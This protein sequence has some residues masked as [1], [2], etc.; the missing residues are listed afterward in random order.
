MGCSSPE[1]SGPDSVPSASGK[2][3]K[4]E[5]SQSSGHLY[6][7]AFAQMKSRIDAQ[8]DQPLIV[9][10]PK[11]A[12]GGYTHEQH[13][14]NA[15][16]IFE[17]G[18]LFEASGEARY[19]D[20]LI[21][22]LDEY[23]GMYSDLPLHPKQKE[24]TPGRLFWQSL[25]EAWWL[26]HAAQGYD[27]IRASLDDET[28]TRVEDGLFHPMVEFL[29][30]GQPQT[31]DK[32]HNHGTWATAAVGLTGY[33]L[34][35]EDYVEKA[36]LGLDLSGEGGFLRQLNVLFSPD[37]YYNE[38]PYY[39]RYALMP[40]VLFAQAIQENEP[41]RDI[42]GQR[43]EILKKAIY[44]TI[45]Q[46]YGG[47]FF[48]INDAIK[49]KDIATTELLHGVS[50]AY[51]LTGDVSLLSIAEAQNRVVP[52]QAG[53]AVSKAINAGKSKPFDYRSMRLADGATG[54]NGAL[55]ILRES[56]DPDGMAV[57]IKNT[58]QG[59]GHG[60]FDKMGLLVFDRGYEILRDYGASRFLNI[61]AK[62]GGHYL[63]ENNLYAKQTIAH[64][65]LVVD[66]TSHFN[67]KTE[68]GNKHAPILGPFVIGEDI[69]ATSA[70]MDTAYPGVTLQRS[71]ALVRHA[72]LEAPILI[73]VVKAK[74]EGLHDYDLPYHY[75][76]QIIE[77]NYEIDADTTSRKPL[78]SDN[79]YQYL[80]QVGEAELP[81]AQAQTT[82]LLDRRFYTLTTAL[83][84]GSH[85]TLAELGA[86]DPNFSLRREPA[87]I[88]SGPRSKSFAA[89]TVFEPHGEYNPTDE[90]TLASR[91][92]VKHVS[93]ISGETTDYI[94]I[95][96]KSG[97]SLSIG[98]S[99][100]ASTDAKNQIDVK[101]QAMSWT[102]PYAFIETKEEK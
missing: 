51:D 58:S 19:A 30:V 47:L 55:D 81:N 76:G 93:H 45:Q 11:D 44:T 90:Y 27:K 46:N 64:N 57:V 71:V 38:G 50:I 89:V 54:K 23:A 94:E 13:K 1:T 31:F 35:R 87:L 40:F 91:S 53:R 67:G 24:Q 68:E 100:N 52:T 78:G 101:G 32:I 62:Y 97:E 70:T 7:A 15:K 14:R 20:H 83:P 4:V 59:L 8:L 72:A 96:L 17:A 65:A 102:G 26:V 73:D 86:N 48:P 28:K 82:L 25:N 95:E 79:G 29:S 6:D 10:V 18:L 85:L 66:Q 98:L 9:P 49:D 41:E 92:Q 42:F 74:G 5:L 22:Y 88:Y 84:L 80:W 16:A 34:D 60:H 61:E 69:S 77:T 99:T 12:G 37:G 43:D 33:A 3:D 36:L 75:N 39:Q 56:N 2:S 21:R 63:P